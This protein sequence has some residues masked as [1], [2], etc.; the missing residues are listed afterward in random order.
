MKQNLLK[1]GVMIVLAMIAS[2]ELLWADNLSTVVYDTCNV[3]QIDSALVKLPVD[4]LA[5]NCCADFEQESTTCWFLRVLNWLKD[6]KKD[7][8]LFLSICCVLLGLLVAFVDAIVIKCKT[9]KWNL[10]ESKWMQVLSIIG[11]VTLSLII[12]DGWFYLIVVALILYY[13]YTKKVFAD[14]LKGI[15]K[16]IKGLYGNDIDLMTANQTQRDAENQK[17]AEEEEKQA[18]PSAFKSG[19]SDVAKDRIQNRA[20]DFERIQTLALDF[21]EKRF[22]TIQRNVIIRNDSHNRIY[23][24]GL[25]MSKYENIIIDIL[26]CTSLTYLE[27]YKIDHVLSAENYLRR[28]TSARTWGIL[29]IVLPQK[30]SLE[31]AKPIFER[32]VNKGINIEVISEEKLKKEVKEPEVIK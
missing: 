22:Q 21:Y 6:Y 20:Q 2:T 11:F 17:K 26:Y 9:G 13:A 5:N 28:K 25:V 29:C 4:Q 7:A 31:K 14:L 32:F 27:N 18:D 12:D 16:F 19:Q 1:Y 3:E 23:L 10:K 30:I 15:Y 24:D 8:L